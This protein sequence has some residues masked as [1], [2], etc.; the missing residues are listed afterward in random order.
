MIYVIDI[1]GT[2][3]TNTNGKYKEAQPF[4]DRIEKINKLYDEGNRI[5]FCTARGMSSLDGD[6]N[7]VYKMWYAYTLEQ[8][9]K[10]NV[11]FHALVLAKPAGDVYIDDKGINSDDFFK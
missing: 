3:C 6:I 2:I 5:I 7:S 1:D 9:K 10:W 4:L 8:L 11:K